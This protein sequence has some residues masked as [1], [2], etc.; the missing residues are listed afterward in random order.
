MALAEIEAL[1]A[2]NADDV[3][4]VTKEHVEKVV[5]MSKSFKKYIKKIHQADP[6][7]LAA[8]RRDRADSP[9]RSATG[10]GAAKPV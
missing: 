7:D 8:S 3:V 4:V 2:D 5:E 6:E 9:N 10:S 1:G